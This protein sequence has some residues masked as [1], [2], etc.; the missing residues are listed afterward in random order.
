[1][2]RTKQ[3]SRK[4]MIVPPGYKVK[5]SKK[6]GKKYLVKDKI[7][8]MPTNPMPIKPYRQPAGT[9][10]DGKIIFLWHHEKDP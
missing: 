8:P 4:L 3:T 7:N 6:T 5:R 10:I 9:V 1:M 2:A